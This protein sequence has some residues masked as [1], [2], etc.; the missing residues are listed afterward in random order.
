MFVETLF[1]QQSKQN[2]FQYP[3]LHTPLFY[4]SEQTGADMYFW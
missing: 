1:L 3:Q 2:G 4:G